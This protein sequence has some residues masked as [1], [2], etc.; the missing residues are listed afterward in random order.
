MANEDLKSFLETRLRALDPGIDTAPGSP[1][2]I[3]FVEP[4]LKRLGTDPFETDVDAFITDR[5]AQ[6]FP[7]IFASDPSAVRDIFIKPLIVLLEPFKREIQAVKL[8]QSLQDPT[9][10]SDDDAD[11]IVANFFDSRDN[12]GFATGSGRLYFANPI[13]L[14]I[15]VATRFFS[16]TGLN[17]YP[18]SAIAI[19]AEEMVFSREGSLFYADVPLRAEA[20]GSEY[21]IGVGQL[22]GVSGIYSVVKVTNVQ[23]FGSGASKQSTSEF[24]SAARES[25]TERS[26]NTRR[27]AAARILQT[28]KADIKS[29]Q[30]VGADDPEM[31]RDLLVAS[32]P[33]HQWLTG[34]V[35]LYK[36]LAYVRCKTVDGE[37]ADSPV[38]GDILYVYITKAVKNG[39]LQSMRLA[40]LTVGTVFLGPLEDVDPYQVSYLVSWT[41]TLPTSIADGTSLPGGLSK[42]TAIKISSFPSSPLSERAV[43]SGGVHVFGHTDMYARPT[44]QPTSTVIWDVLRNDNA[45]DTVILE[46]QELVVAALDYWVRDSSPINYANAGVLEGDILTIHEGPSAGAYK[47][48]SVDSIRVGLDSIPSTPGTYRYSITRKFHVNAFA[49]KDRKFPFGGATA[50]D[51]TTTSGVNEVRTTVD[52]TAYGASIGDTLRITNGLSAGDYSIAGFVSDVAGFGVQVDRVMGGAESGLSYEV[53]SSLPAINKPL[54]RIKGIS[55]LDAAGQ[56]TG[57]SVP[58]AKPVGVLPLGDF[59]SAR[60]RGGSISNSGFVLPDMTNLTPASNFAAPSGDR[61]YSMGFDPADGTYYGVQFDNLAWSELLFRNDA[62]GGAN[63]FVA[64]VESS[65]KAEN[66]P[67]IDPS[68]GEALDILTGP[69]KGSYLIKAVH[70][71]KYHT[72]TSDNWVYFIQIHGTFKFD[73]FK[74]LISFMQVSGM[75]DQDLGLEYPALGLA[76]PDGFPGFFVNW[77]DSLGTKLEQALANYQVTNPPSPEFLQASIASQALVD[78]S[79]GSPARGVLRTYF[80]EPVLFEQRTASAASPTLYDYRTAGGDT[81]SF[82]PELTR[83][84]SNIL[85]PPKLTAEIDARSKARDAVFTTDQLNSTS[86]HTWGYGLR[87]G[88]VVQ[89]HDEIKI[90]PA[91]DVNDAMAVVTVSGSTT[92]SAPPDS[93][94][95]FPSSLAGSYLFIEEGNDAGGYIITDVPAPDTLVLDHAPNLSTRPIITDKSG[96]DGVIVGSTSTLSSAA[97]FEPG[98][99]GRYVTFY[100]IDYRFMGSYQIASVDPGGHDL[101]FTHP[102]GNV[103]PS[104][105]GV[106]WCITTAPTTA[107]T[108]IERSGGTGTELVGA[109]MVRLYKRLPTERTITQIIPPGFPFQLIMSGTAPTGYR[110]P[111]SVVR[112]NVRRINTTEMEAN[113]EGSLF[114]FDTEVVSFTATSDAN[115]SK[116]SYLELRDGT[117]TSWGYDL[118][119]ASPSFSYSTKEELTL[120][121]PASVLPSGVEDSLF[122]LLPLSGMSVQITYEQ[123]DAISI[124]QNFLESPEDRVTS[125]NMLARHFLP[126]YVAYDSTYVGGSA[127]GVVAKD[128][129]EYIKALPVETALDISLIEKLI[130]DRG[131]NVVTPT[132]I[133]AIVHDW[134]RNRWLVMSDNELTGVVPVPSYKGSSRVTYFVAGPDY[135]GKDQMPSGERVSL[136]RL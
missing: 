80:T 50:T 102:Y 30:V 64:T 63:Y 10:L 78:Y 28:F 124:L 83:Y 134:E 22:S 127:T 108:V 136:T 3:Q 33:G 52:L 20:A 36:N 72:G 97:L 55:I 12:G 41:G 68:P 5:F 87:L 90:S 24:I 23:N 7:E 96:S 94:L 65:D 100:N 79:W 48:V 85:V 1:A 75:T 122:N 104:Q 77:F 42:N 126:A 56:E 57:M 121:L 95:V 29:V 27:G 40:R 35:T 4:V 25:L 103:V 44:L 38:P 91:N 106:G 82:R 16:S 32:S 129:I 34:D 60:V 86:V 89:I 14:T 109:Q 84:S 101:V 118:Q 99:V 88:D 69:N 133:V 93:G 31:Q 62:K 110:Q 45:L 43:D 120:Q 135:S 117:Y 107:P 49:P 46:R 6:E 81:V 123:S 131:G 71:F 17:F 105:S 18:L 54:V 19:T 114:Y 26:L 111:Y 112:N 47:I 37:V 74:E 67:P 51:L 115:I 21:N 39:L 61:R 113:V 73:L 9:V 130:S 53:F 13:T 92:V 58:P 76:Y 132:K 98:D 15:D 125:A 70:K 2:Q 59:T 116:G 66:F 8:N 119:V 128:I 11:A